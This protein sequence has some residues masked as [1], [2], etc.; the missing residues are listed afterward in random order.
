M[1]DD[2]STTRRGFLKASAA[3]AGI[4]AP[5]FVPA[6][7]LGRDGAVAA[8]ERVTVGLIG[9]GDHGVGRNLKRFLPESDCQVIA[10]CDVDSKRLDGAVNM[11]NERYAEAKAKGTYKGCS[12][13]RDFREIIERKDIDVVMNATPDH[14]HVIPAIMAA[15]AGKDV[16]CEK[17]LSLTV[18][19]G[20]ALADTV[21]KH[22]R[23]SQ[24]ASENRSYEC[25]YR[26]AELVR[27]GRIGELKRIEVTLPRGHS[28]H[29]A[30]M[31]FTPPPKHLDYD[32]WLGQAPY[33][34]YCEAR[35]H[36]NFRWIIDYSGGMLT[37]WGAH[38]IDIAQWGNDTERTGPVEVEGKAEFALNQLY[39]A[40][41]EFNIDYKYANGVELNVSSSQ[42]GI[43]FIGT[44]GWIGNEGWN[45]PLKAEPASV[46]DSKIGPDEIHLYNDPRGEQRNF[47]DGVRTRKPCY[48]PFEVGHRTITI[49][50]IGH[51]SMTLGRKLKWNPDDERFV[52]DD[53]ANK[54][55]SRPMRE[56]WTL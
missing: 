45:Q 7:A 54:F 46:L 53:E 6:F 28:I 31:E 37:D 17:P 26:S 50:H 11:T 10:L 19:E 52:D 32:M 35:C 42:P 56:P 5:L 20:R 9:T 12:A 30:S 18:A 1:L 40:A 15:R 44:E 21:K 2:K 48:A 41:K 51:I 29:E 47:L 34:P 13:H 36:W 25:Y 43:K 22:G 23:I 27:N 3:A 39:N 49:A 8:N 14:W 38:L 55:L 33:R 4:A 24:T 16:M